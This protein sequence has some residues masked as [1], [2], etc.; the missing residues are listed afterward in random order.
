MNGTEI[1]WR[2][3]YVD[4]VPSTMEVIDAAAATGEPAG[5]VVVADHQTAGRGRSG[6]SW[7]DR[8]GDALLCSILL[9]PRIP[10][11]HIGVVSL[12]AGVALCEAIESLTTARPRLRW[13]NDLLL[14]QRKLAGILATS[15]LAAGAIAHVNL[16]IG[17]NLRG[18]DGLPENAA[19]LAEFGRVERSALL[20]ALLDEL[21]RRLPE[22]E[23]GD[24]RPIL[25]AW[26]QRAAFVGLQ[27]VVRTE[28]GTI[29]GRLAGVD[30][31]G[32]LVLIDQT[33]E[34]RRVVAGDLTRGPR[35]TAGRVEL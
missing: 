27:V 17:L 26:E 8:P 28:T 29:E 30:D 10:P 32:A 34:R 7:L 14:D 4:T 5:L 1:T 2:V 22:L 18:G 23:A 13:P 3:R 16:G 6:R 20:A 12:L 19:S 15:R 25:A 35:R 31:D 9:R 21:N 24:Q 33:G 11:R